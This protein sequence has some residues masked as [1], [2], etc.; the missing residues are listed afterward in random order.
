LGRRGVQ[1]LL[2]IGYPPCPGHFTADNPFLV[3]PLSG[4]QGHFRQWVSQWDL[5]EIAEALL[6][7]DLRGL[8]GD[9]A[10]AGQ[11]QDF[12]EELL[13]QNPRFL[14]RLNRL[15]TR[16]Q[17]PLGFLGQ[18]VLEHDG[19]HE[20]EL[21]IK[22]RGLVP[23]VD[24]V[25]FLAIQY[26]LRET[27]TLSRLDLL[28]HVGALPAGMAGELAQGFEFLLNLRLRLEGEK[29]RAGEPVSYYLNPETLSLL[30]RQLLKETFKIIKQAQTYVRQK[31]HVR[32]GRFY[33]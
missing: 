27:N 30:D 26:Q 29:I 9:M 14:D 5:A 11:L 19:Q 32:V 15:S 22:R 28:K 1:A 10:L 6:F 2:D 7:F 16:Q 12:V 13:V 17:P 21:D 20:N 33:G 4:W 25:R 3:Q 24:L 23:L 31:T 8:Y 18:L